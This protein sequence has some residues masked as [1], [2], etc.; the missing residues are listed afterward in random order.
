MDLEVLASGCRFETRCADRME[1]CT[2]SEPTAVA[3]DETH[4]VSCFKYGG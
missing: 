4:V 3:V 1:R 2:K